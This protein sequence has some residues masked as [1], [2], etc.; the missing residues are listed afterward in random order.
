MLGVDGAAVFT[1]RERVVNW[2]VGIRSRKGWQQGGI[3][4][5]GSGRRQKITSIRNRTG[6]MVARYRSY[7]FTGSRLLMTISGTCSCPLRRLSRGRI[8]HRVGSVL[9][10]VGQDSPNSFLKRAMV[11][12]ILRIDVANQARNSTGK[13]IDKN[14]SSVVIG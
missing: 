5:W 1:Y 9:L 10:I 2:M 14:V 6:A 4:E 11:T 12:P 8:F 13:D 3:E 7:L